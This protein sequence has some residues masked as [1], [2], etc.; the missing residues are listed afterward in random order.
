MRLFLKI[1]YFFSG[2]LIFL[3]ISFSFF[4]FYSNHIEVNWIEKRKVVIVDK[5]LYKSL[6]G[7]KV[8]HFSDLDLRNPGLREER[9]LR[10]L[11]AIKPDVVFFTGDFI[12]SRIYFK[13][14]LKIFSHIKPRFSIYAVL[15][16]NDQSNFKD[17][18]LMKEELKKAGVV[19]LINKAVRLSFDKRPSFWL[20]GL[21]PR[22]D[23]PDYILRK[24]DDGRPKIL[25]SH[26]PANVYKASQ[27]GIKL[28]LSGDTHGGQINPWFLRDLSD[29]SRSKE[30][31]FVSGLY[32]V[33]D[34]LLYVNRGIG[35]SQRNIRFLC[36]PEITIF[37]FRQEGKPSLA[38]A[39]EYIEKNLL[40]RALRFIYDRLGIKDALK[41]IYRLILK[42]VS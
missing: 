6:G 12:D 25:L 9:L 26:F 28:V 19:T 7:L 39:P 29:F 22:R 3:I 24:I 4:Y 8:V 10:I 27:L 42:M 18:N 33:D 37:E 31:E 14:A 16:D 11:K 23:F 17:R 2:F 40:R 20:I 13:D 38:R 36:R 15:G 5:Q 41:A 30:T 32:K 35:T 1:G 21:E 34:T